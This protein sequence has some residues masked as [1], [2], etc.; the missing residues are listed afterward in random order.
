MSRH[1][2]DFTRDA[3]VAAPGRLRAHAAPPRRR[4][5]P[6]VAAAVDVRGQARD[7]EGQLR[8]ALRLAQARPG[9]EH[10]PPQ[11]ASTRRRGTRDLPRELRPRRR[12]RR[13]RFAAA[14]P[15]ASALKVPI[16]AVTGPLVAVVTGSVRSLA[17]QAD[18][19]PPRRRRPSRTP[20]S[21]PSRPARRRR[22]THRDRHQPHEG[23]R[24][25]RSGRSRSPSGCRATSPDQ[26][27]GRARAR[28]RRRRRSRPGTPP[29]RAGAVTSRRPGT[30]GS[31]RRCAGRGATPSASP[32]PAGNGATVRS[33]QA[34]QRRARRLRPLR[35]HVPRPRPP[36]LRR[37]GRG[38][39]QRAA[40]GHTHQGQDVFARCGTPLVAARGGRVKF[41]QYHAAAGN[42]LVI[43]GGGHGPG[44]RLH[45]P[46]RALAVLARRPRLHRPAHRLGGRHG[47]RQRLPP[48]LRD[49]AR[50]PA[51]TTAGSP[52]DP[53]PSLQAWDAWS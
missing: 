46:G 35:Q 17:T 39:R 42:Y 27:A 53:L 23:L 12:H 24:R 38:L 30:A 45:A 32:P 15:P 37:L 51:G 49:V 9:R 6:A 28:E 3:H 19:D 14:G 52:F 13:A 43:D 8:P 1:S 44:L 29:R 47:Q 26:L 7:H 20:S 31:G 50:R 22:P 34:R 36:Q 11:R 2:R 5:R 41:K 21:R 4:P 40:P 48:P 18:R 16:G 25:T 33:A 10:A